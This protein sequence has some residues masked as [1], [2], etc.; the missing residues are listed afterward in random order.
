LKI[1]IK[2]RG[3]I[4]FLN[5]DLCQIKDCY[6]EAEKLYSDPEHPTIDVCLEHYI[7]LMRE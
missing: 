3:D 5:L 7:R 6:G 4:D 2:S 1:E